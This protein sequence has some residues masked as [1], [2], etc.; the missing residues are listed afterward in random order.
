MRTLEQGALSNERWTP[1]ALADE[2]ES[3]RAAR[4]EDNPELELFASEEWKLACRI[5]TSKGMAKSELLP[6]FLLHICEMSLRGRKE[7]ITEQRIGMLIFNRPA[8][9]NP[10]EDNIVRSYA[11]TL[12]KRLDDYFSQDGRDEPLRMTIPR[13]GYVPAFE[14]APPEDRRTEDSA[15]LTA[16]LPA[17]I[18]AQSLPAALKQES[19]D[20]ELA[21]VA[22]E[23]GHD[24]RVWLAAVLGMLGGALL[25]TAIWFA[26]AVAHRGR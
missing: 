10:G 15:P 25:A 14:L 6:R 3:W 24:R 5:A 4:Q 12:R 7:E 2:C 26:S 17:I 21:A 9:Y 23:T 13:G 20:A 16:V 19:P 1:S 22:T 18:A 8:G 11:R